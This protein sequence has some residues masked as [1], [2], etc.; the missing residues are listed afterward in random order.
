MQETE[1]T[2]GR[3][4]SAPTGSCLIFVFS[5][6]RM[7]SFRNASSAK[8]DY[9]IQETDQTQRY[10]TALGASSL[11]R[12]SGF[13]IRVTRQGPASSLAIEACRGLTAVAFRSVLFFSSP[14]LILHIATGW[15]DAPAGRRGAGRRCRGRWPCLSISEADMSSE[16]TSSGLRERQDLAVDLSSGYW[17]MSFCPLDLLAVFSGGRPPTAPCDCITPATDLGRCCSISR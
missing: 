3:Q 12:H 14:Y 16:Q 13:V 17:L 7:T 9:L 11:I 6:A 5:K 4:F 15:G 1:E 8:F 2:G 10:G